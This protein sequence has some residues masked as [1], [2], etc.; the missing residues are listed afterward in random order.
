MNLSGALKGIYNVNHHQM[1]VGN[2]EG[3]WKR[4]IEAVRQWKMFDLPWVELCWPDAP[5]EDGETVAVLIW[6]L[7]F[8]SLNANRIVY[9]I[10]EPTRF[11]FAYGTL[12]EHAESGEE[13][14]MVEFDQV[15]G[16]IS[17]DILAFSKPNHFL[18]NLGFPLTR[19]LQKQFALDSMSAMRRAIK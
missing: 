14:F 17:Y 3:D 19:Y 5:I 12:A 9:V 1:V 4:A 15:T 11:G 8:H 2:G 16:D 13:R 10:D 6:H 18:A 7:G